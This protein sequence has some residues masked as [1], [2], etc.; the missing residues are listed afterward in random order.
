[1]EPILFLM[2]MAGIV[3]IVWWSV[4]NDMYSDPAET[5]GLLA[6][7]GDETKAANKKKNRKFADLPVA[8][9]SRFRAIPVTKEQTGTQSRN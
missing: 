2:S 6:M 8:L 9:S 7:R 4:V 5:E 1:M 3:A